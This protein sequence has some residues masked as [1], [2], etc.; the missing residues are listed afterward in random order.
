[1]KQRIEVT[2]MNI[3]LPD[4]YQ[5][6]FDYYVISSL[7]PPI[8]IAMVKLP[9]T[10]KEPFAAELEETSEA[11]L[12]WNLKN[13]VDEVDEQ[14][15]N[16]V[17]RYELYGSIHVQKEQAPPTSQEEA[18][19]IISQFIDELDRTGQKDGYV[20]FPKAM[21]DGRHEERYIFQPIEEKMF[22]T[23]TERGM[24]EEVAWSPFGTIDEAT[25]QEAQNLE[26]NPLMRNWS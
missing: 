8:K 7:I 11:I 23:R 13:R 19:A 12:V 14:G 18:D 9:T 26:R 15:E 20:Y 2:P 22:T 25:K 4:E 3:I 24:Y 10:L 6:D 16:P 1:M 21:R 5:S 17:S